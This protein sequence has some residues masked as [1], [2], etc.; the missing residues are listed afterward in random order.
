MG[1][2][3]P[4]CVMTWQI[5]SVLLTMIAAVCTMMSVSIQAACTFIRIQDVQLK[6]EVA[7]GA[8]RVMGEVNTGDRAR[9][10]I[11]ESESGISA[12]PEEPVLA[13]Q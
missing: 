8:F 3:F 4:D 11:C 1:H 5:A 13:D 9:L 7:F 2:E 10:A 12:S 6:I